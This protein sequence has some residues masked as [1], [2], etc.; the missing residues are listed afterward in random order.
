[1]VGQIARGNREDFTFLPVT[2]S[3]VLVAASV[4]LTAATVP[5]VVE[6]LAP[7]RGRRG[8]PV[9]LGVVGLVLAALAV[10]AVTSVLG[11]YHA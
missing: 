10:F 8:H 11:A 3:L 2:L 9:Q 6:R 1:M 4:A 5:L 7:D